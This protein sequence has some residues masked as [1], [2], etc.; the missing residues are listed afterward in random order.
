ML[1]YDRILQKRMT[2]LKRTTALIVPVIC[3]VMLLAQTVFAKNTYR[4][5]D[6][7]R[8]VIHTTYSTDPAT[9]LD[10]AGLELGADDTYTTQS[11]A[12]VS[13]ITIQRLQ[14]I[15]IEQWG[16]TQQV[17]SYGETVEALLSRLNVTLTSDDLVSVSLDTQ[18]RDGMTITISRSTTIEEVTTVSIPY[19]VVYCY[20]P[21]LSAGEECILTPGVVGQLLRTETVSLL[22]GQEV[23]RTV[24]REDVL[25]Q[26]VTAIIAVGTYT[27][28]MAP[29]TEPTEPPVTTAPPT[30]TVPPTTV[31]ETTVPPTTVPETTVPPTTVPPTT[32]AP[33]EEASTAP[34]D[35]KPIIT[36]G[37]ITTPE[38][39]VLTFSYA[40]VFKATAYTHTDP[41]CNEWTST[42]THVRVGVVAVDPDVIPYGTRMYIVSNDGQYIY[43]E[44]VAEDCGSSIKNNR[45]DLYFETDAECWAFGIRNCTIYFLN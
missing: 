32:E 26:P 14:S 35:N 10:E 34:A 5:T 19:E 30:T 44:A 17:T 40:A 28:Q 15:T 42:G 41:G 2:M 43:G 12:G 39:E 9:V 38:G 27:Q 8:V 31:P 22:D 4:I 3:I 11:G 29:E 18:T 20:D 13:E 45:I 36:N 6:G 33:S 23:L 24:I 21:T 25:T 7:N 1:E 37:T 16:V